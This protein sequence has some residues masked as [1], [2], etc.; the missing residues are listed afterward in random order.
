VRLV[1]RRHLAAL[2][3]AF[4]ATAYGAIVL[5]PFAQTAT[6]NVERDGH[7]VVALNQAG[8]YVFCRKYSSISPFDFARVTAGRYANLVEQRW[9]STERFCAQT[10]QPFLNNENGLFF[11][12]TALMRPSDTI[13]G[14]ARKLISFR[15]A[16]IFCGLYALALVGFGIVPLGVIALLVTNAVGLTQHT[17]LMSV[18]PIMAVIV[19]LGGA[20]AVGLFAAVRHGTMTAAI[21]AVACG[22]VTAFVYNLRSSYLAVIVAQ[23]ALPLVVHALWFGSSGLKRYA[24]VLAGIAVGFAAFQFALVRPLPS[25]DFNY[26]HH[27][28]WHPLVLGLALPPNDFASAHGIQWNDTV[29]LALAREVDPSVQYLGSGYERALREYYFRLWRRYPGELIALYHTKMHETAKSLAY[30]LFSMGRFPPQQDL[31]KAIEGILGN[32]YFWLAVIV[33]LGYFWTRRLP[34]NPAASAFALSLF[35]AIVIVFVEQTAITSVFTMNNQAALGV[36]LWTLLVLTLAMLFPTSAHY[37]P[38][39]G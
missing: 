7:A 16:L 30:T 36:A 20:V 12:M 28:V 14:L 15:V 10:F 2:A 18:Y 35:A 33:A 6:L 32:A 3:I 26:S 1:I 11:I 29:G 27:T 34:A 25:L 37:R 22:V 17:H 4:I 39:A 24:A 31:P 38:A 5:N 13:H 21:A 8:S 23:L 19:L 9:G